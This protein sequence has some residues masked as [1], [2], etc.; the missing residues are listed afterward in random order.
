M[1]TIA[2]LDAQIAELEKQKKVQLQKAKDAAIDKVMKAINELNALGYSY[3]LGNEDTAA[4]TRS[5]RSGVRDDVL[6]TVK[7]NPGT[8]PAEIAE[9]LGL[10]DRKGKQSIANALSALKKAGQVT[11]ENRAYTAT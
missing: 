9:Q 5:R 2:E 11:A 8:K 10:T 1:P 7:A 4:S 3:F 6:K